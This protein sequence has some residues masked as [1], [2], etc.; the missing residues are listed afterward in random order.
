M[1]QEQHS[2][3]NHTPAQ[4]WLARVS[5]NLLST[6]RT[7]SSI[8]YQIYTN[9]EVNTAEVIS[10]PWFGQI[11]VL[12]LRPLKKKNIKNLKSKFLAETNVFK[13]TTVWG[14]VYSLKTVTPLW[15][16]TSE[17]AW[18]D[19]GARPPLSTTWVP[20]APG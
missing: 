8:P 16:T 4:A 6:I 1:F 5:V 18:L 11:Q 14:V 15:T 20:W 3:T 9:V 17:E 19:P 2:R 12:N 7:T 10:K 13:V